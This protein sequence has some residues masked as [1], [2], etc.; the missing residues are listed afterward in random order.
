MGVFLQARCGRIP[1]VFLPQ[2]KASPV[3]PILSLQ[4]AVVHSA[5][6]GIPRDFWY[7]L[8]VVFSLVW[9]GGGGGQL[10]KPTPGARSPLLLLRCLLIIFN[11]RFLK[12]V[13]FTSILFCLPLHSS[14][15]TVQE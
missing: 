12:S 9:G 13:R 2:L 10:N 7:L 15:V 4:D 5:V 14:S 3:R 8:P 1:S 6:L 11:L